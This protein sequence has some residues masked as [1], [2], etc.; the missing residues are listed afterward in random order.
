M[1]SLS[2]LETSAMK[3][4]NSIEINQALAE[5]YAK[6]GR[7]QEATKTYQTL[8]SLYPSTASLFT[9]RI[10]L[11][12]SALMISSVLFL[13]AELFLP[14]IAAQTD[15]ENFAQSISPPEFLT[16]QILFILAFALYSCSA[17][18]IYKLLSYTRDH[19]PAFWAMVLSVIGVGLS[20]PL[21]GIKAFVLPLIGRLYLDG[22]TSALSLYFA[23]Q[24]NTWQFMLQ[25]GNYFVIAGITIFSWV[26][27]RNRNLSQ[28][29]I[30]IYLAGWIGFAFSNNQLPKLGLILI[31]LLISLGGV[32]FGRSLWIQASVQFYPGMD[33]LSRL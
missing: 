33:R 20:M 27:W 24:Q 31:G 28:S 21:L 9:N 1:Q 30:L 29:A 17:I 6:E 7:W 10:R 16:A 19:R 15:P 12:A 18:S 3:Q 5:A 14:S 8:A 22:E 32:G 25:S 26:I 4:P 11:G 23:M 2:Q 13:I